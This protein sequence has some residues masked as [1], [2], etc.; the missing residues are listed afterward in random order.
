MRP[1]NLL[2]IAALLSLLLLTIHVT[3]DIVRGFD[4]AGLVN[5]IGIGVAA[6]LL[7]GT[8]ILRE[9]LSGHI[10]MLLISIFAAGM[11]IIHLRSPHINDVARSDGGF[12]FI[13]TLWALGVIGIFGIMLAVRGLWE[14]RRT[15]KASKRDDEAPPL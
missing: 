6:V 8:L 1:N 11:P 4:Q 9:R 14:L 7:Y 5:M 10:I 15:K 3:D 13:W 2:T 12:F